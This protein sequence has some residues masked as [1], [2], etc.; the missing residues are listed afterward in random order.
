MKA[1]R[2]KF[3]IIFIL[4]SVQL[5][6]SAQ[7]AGSGTISGRITS[8]GGEAVSYA[9][10]RL[11]GTACAAHT[12]IEGIYQIKAPAGR[13]SL[14][15]S[16]VGHKTVERD[17]SVEAGGSQHIDIRMKEDAIQLDEVSVVSAG[18][19]RVKNSAYNAVAVDT[20]DM[21][22]TTKT[23]SEALAKTPGLKLRES[24][25]VGSDMNLML[26]GFSGKHVKIF[27][28]G[29]PQEGV[30]SSFGLNNIPV[31]FADR[32]EVYKGVVPVAFGTDAIGGVVN[33]VTNRK[34][35]RWFVDASYSYGSFNTHKSYINFGQSF[36]NG[37]TY[38]IN[39]FQNYSDNSYR[40]DAPVFDFGSQSIDTKKLY[41]V[42]RF[43]DTYHNEVVVAKFGFMGKSWADRLMLGFTYSHMYKEIQT[44]VRQKTVYGQKH[45]HGHSLMPSLEY[46]KRNLFTKGLDVTLTANYNRNATFN[47]DTAS[48][49][50][51][52][53]GERRRTSSPG[54]QTYQYL[55]ADN[56]NWNATLNTTYRIGTAHALTLNNVF[57][58]FS[59]DNTSLLYGR[60][61][62]DPISKDMRKNITGLSYRFMP[63]ERW[64]VSLFGK[65]YSQY[66]SGPVAADENA[67]S[68]V[69]TSRTIDSW[70]YGAAATC[71]I[72][73]DLQAKLSYEKACRLPTIEEMFGDEDLESGSVLIRPE[74]SDNINLS[75]SWSKTF[76]RHS[77]YV[78][79]GMVYRD[80]RDYIQ[81]SIA[82]LS[83][84]REGAYYENYGRVKTAGFNLS[85]R[86]TL[87]RWLSVGGN[88]TRMDVRDNEKLMVGSTSVANPMYHTRMPNVPWQFA[89]A[90]VNLYWHNLLKDG[91]TLTLTYDNQYL[92]SFCYY[93]DGVQ[94]ANLSDYM[95]PTQFSHNLTLT[96]SMSRGRYNVSLECR[97]FTNEKLYDNFSLQKAGRAFYGKVRVYLGK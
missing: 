31:S 42:R 39:A 30:G 79:G 75:L 83:G 13:Y 70:G 10:I 84:N 22:N 15:V 80:T 86:Y 3:V 49:R 26:D 27:I 77:L 76:G 82:E 50:Y 63:S 57:N 69:R 94:A 90:D 32:I 16:A 1:N 2:L 54:E 28:D 96:Y 46:S 71:F 95:V 87:G 20:R 21:L 91:N 7:S 34:R 56:N 74:K 43:N 4:L 88:F 81:R 78:E 66:V 8:S 93:S 37:L 38:E 85:A 64:N 5:A 65:Y 36:S 53:L 17:V 72:V 25:G 48:Y 61:D 29:V 44:G 68:Y 51:N 14:V 47:V 23:L 6:V 19:S 92:H 35:R 40:V 97:N 45:R 67:S 52:W 9:T 41:S 73:D 55:R 11:K 62:K 60:E 33:I 59:R 12:D 18:V 24:G 58:S 89:D